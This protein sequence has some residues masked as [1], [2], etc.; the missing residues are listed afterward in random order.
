MLSSLSP[1]LPNLS[2]GAGIFVALVVF[3][4]GVLRGFTGFGFALAAVPTIT[5][6]VAPVEVVPAIVIVAM[7]AGAELLPKV[8][9]S[10]H[11]PSMRLLLGGGALGTPLGMYA[12][13]T[14]PAD[15]MRAI[16]GVTV[17]AAVLFLWRGFKL[18]VAPPRRMRIGIGAVSGL[19]NG[20]TAMG[21]PPVI[22]YFLASPEGVAVG[23]ASLLVYFFFLSIW[24]TVVN[25]VGGLLTLRTLVFAGLM[26]P[27]MFAGN[28]IGDRW[29]DKS[30]A[31]AYE[32]IAL[33]FLA[34][35]AVLTLA[36]AIAG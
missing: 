27:F 9:R 12:L 6:F 11:W 13:K 19:L 32:R 3:A 1:Y 20:G 16:I 14:L 5:L 8:W 35:I 17:L 30:S 25:G 24:S 21:G 29:F 7:L 34:G 18:A 26:L 15:A 2:F 23:R 4:A 31:A 28:R 22:I 33:V 10:I 36:R